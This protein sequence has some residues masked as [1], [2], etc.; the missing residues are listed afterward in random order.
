MLRRL[1]LKQMYNLVE[2]KDASE[3]ATT[4]G[5]FPCLEELT[6][7]ECHHLKS[8]PCD[9]P[10]L[11]KLWI[12]E[13]RSM[14]FE[15]ISSKLTT[16]KSLYIKNVSELACLPE[17][18]IENNKGL[19]IRRCHELET[20]YQ[21]ALRTIL[22]LEEFIVESCPNL[23]SLPSIQGIVSFLRCLEISC[24]DEVLSI[25]DKRVS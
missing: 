3:L 10:F 23:R 21:D 12:S 6:I 17:Q 1:E 14:A 5:V 7:E 4:V 22:G 9:F 18:L 13:I 19:Q 20:I 11:Q 2:W 8:A 15:N 24:G 25:D 16:L